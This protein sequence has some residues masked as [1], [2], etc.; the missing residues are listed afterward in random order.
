MEETAP[1]GG[2][3]WRRLLL[4]EVRGGAGVCQSCSR[5]GGVAPSLADKMFRRCLEGSR[6]EEEEV[7]RGGGQP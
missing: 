6:R 3:K 7:G 5:S 4:E 1:G 2:E